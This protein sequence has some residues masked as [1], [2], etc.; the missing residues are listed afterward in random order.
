MKQVNGSPKWDTYWRDLPW[1]V[2]LLCQ[3]HLALLQRTHQVHVLKLIAEI[4][5]LL[6]QSNESPFDFQRDGSALL[7]GLE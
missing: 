1:Q 3:D 4:N 5:G 6:D 7:N 2:H